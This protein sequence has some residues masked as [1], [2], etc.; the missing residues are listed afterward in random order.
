MKTNYL[1][2]PN[3]GSTKFKWDKDSYFDNGVTIS[4]ICDCGVKGE[5]KINITEG[6]KCITYYLTDKENR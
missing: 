1:K 3:C 5:N 2:C 4:F 6:T